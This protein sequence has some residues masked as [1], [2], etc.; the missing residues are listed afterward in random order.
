MSGDIT[1]AVKI[2]SP[3]P[4]CRHL[5]CHTVVYARQDRY[6][7][8]TGDKKPVDFL[9]LAFILVLAFILL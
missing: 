9:L 8:E 4:L 7:H 6:P 2:S 3:P 5:D 1:I